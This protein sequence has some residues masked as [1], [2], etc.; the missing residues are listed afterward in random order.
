[1][2]EEGIMQILRSTETEEY[3]LPD[4]CPESEE[5]IED[6]RRSSLEGKYSFINVIVLSVV[7]IACAVYFISLTSGDRYGDEGVQ[8]SPKGLVDGSVTAEISRRYYSTVPY[9]E[10]TDKLYEKLSSFYGITGEGRNS[11]D[12]LRRELD[13]ISPEDHTPMTVT[14]RKPHRENEVSTTTTTGETDTSVTT[15]APSPDQ[16][17]TIF[18]RTTTVSSALN[19]D[20]LN[21]YKTTAASVTTTTNNTP[22]PATSTTTLPPP[23]SSAPEDQPGNG[24]NE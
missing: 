15:S 1:M 22:P 11:A 23:A 21:P 9:P 7:L 3:V 14:T 6:L 17:G 19:F 20:P 10:Q 5:A 2:T 13:I 4:E 12:E 8:I 18:S 16:S 24:G